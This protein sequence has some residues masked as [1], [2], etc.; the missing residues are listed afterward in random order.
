MKRLIKNYTTAIPVEQTVAE[1]QKILS[2][3]V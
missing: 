1:I 2:E 3:P